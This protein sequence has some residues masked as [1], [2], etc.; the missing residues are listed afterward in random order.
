MKKRPFW[1]DQTQAEAINCR[2]CGEMLDAH[3]SKPTSPRPD[4]GRGRYLED[5]P[6]EATRCPAC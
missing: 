4:K 5:V 1:A 3:R 6:R 2:W